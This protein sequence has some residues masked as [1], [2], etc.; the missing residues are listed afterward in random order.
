MQHKR[1]ETKQNKGYMHS[2]ITEDSSNVRLG[3]RKKTNI[4]FNASYLY[5][6]P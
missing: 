3:F 6:I 1:F 2:E 5:E 4:L